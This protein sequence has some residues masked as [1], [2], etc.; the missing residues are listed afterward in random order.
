MSRLCSCICFGIG[1][2]N[3]CGLFLW[4]AGKE[5]GTIRRTMNK[6][7]HSLVT[8]FTQVLSVLASV[9][10]S[11]FWYFSEQ[12]YDFVKRVE[13]STHQI[14]FSW[15]VGILSSCFVNQVSKAMSKKEGIVTGVLTISLKHERANNTLIVHVDKAR[16]LRLHM[17]NAA[18]VTNPYVKVIPAR[19]LNR[20]T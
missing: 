9:G 13:S 11:F 2:S 18:H 8:P 6:I 4:Q 20:C 7:G 5:T 19:T 10:S 1:C 16:A 15:Y 12:S 14:L 3:P 17:K